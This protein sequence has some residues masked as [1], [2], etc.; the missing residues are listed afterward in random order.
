M[1]Q[2]IITDYYDTMVTMLC[3]AALFTYIIVE[4]ILD[5]K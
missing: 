3:W 2:A 5:R 4:A 1:E